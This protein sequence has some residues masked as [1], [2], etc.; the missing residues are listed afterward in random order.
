LEFLFF[1]WVILHC[2]QPPFS[3]LANDPVLYRDFV[4][5]LRGHCDEPRFLSVE[6]PLRWRI[7][8]C[9]CVCVVKQ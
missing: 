4:C 2:L 5:L 7:A 1:A 3:A 8:C 6:F 9:V